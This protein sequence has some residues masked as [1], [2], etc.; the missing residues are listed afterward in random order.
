MKDKTIYIAEALPG[1]GKTEAFIKQLDTDPYKRYLYAVPTKVLSKD[2]LK[3]IQ[4][5][6]I[7]HVYVINSDTHK[8]V[9]EAVEC[10][11][12]EDDPKVLVITHKTL[13][14][15]DPCYLQDWHVVI[16]ESPT[17]ANN[18]TRDIG[19]HAYANFLEKFIEID[20]GSTRASIKRGM[21]REARS[22]Y[23]DVATDKGMSTIAS[24][25][26]ALLRGRADVF[27]SSFL[28]KHTDKWKWK[29]RMI[30]YFDLSTIF[31]HARETHILGANVTKTLAYQHALSKGYDIQPSKFTPKRKGYKFASHIYPL[32]AGNKVSK[33]MLLTM[34]DGSVSEEWNDQVY[35]NIPIRNALDYANGEPILVQVHDWCKFPFDEHPNALRIPFD[36]RGLN[37]YSDVYHTL[38]LIHGNPSPIEDQNNSEML[39]KMG[40]S[41][42]TGKAALRN[43]RYRELIFQAATRSSIRT[44][45]NDRPT[46]HF[47]PTEE[48]GLHL[49]FDLKGCSFVLKDLTREPPA[50]AHSN[51]LEAK[52]ANA[53]ALSNEGL[54]ARKIASMLGVSNSTVSLWLK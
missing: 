5:I 44:F 10:A 13:L 26:G 23:A 41:S 49:A 16:D 50:S 18:L 24:C 27:I 35:G 51:K 48:S 4:A 52:I 53:K 2:V 45:K 54:S 36:A 40:V 14:D 11:L 17:V 31:E 9:T 39:V 19:D 3:R 25:L 28:D 30:D 42:E 33:T 20:E 37:T 7:Q 43:E 6:D 46:I 1:A 21:S 29:I 38:S 12:L 47:V 8:H 15:I 34:P 22:T 32:I